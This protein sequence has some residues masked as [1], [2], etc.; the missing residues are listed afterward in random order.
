MGGLVLVAR[1]LCLF[2][3]KLGMANLSGEAL[4]FS[5]G[6]SSGYECGFESVY[7]VGRRFSLQFYVV[8]LSFI[9]FDLEI[10]LFLPLVGSNLVGVGLVWGIFF[11]ICVF[12]VYLF[13]LNQGALAW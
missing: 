1:L 13:E 9:I 8:G 10:S 11:L 2:L 4:S 12:L 5:L 6:E 7:V 3:V